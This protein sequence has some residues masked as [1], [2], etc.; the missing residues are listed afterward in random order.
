MKS[1][2]KTIGSLTV[3]KIIA[4][5]TGLAY[6]VLQ[7]RYF[8][9]NAAMDA[10]FVALTAVY[11][12]TSIL[13]SGQLAEVFL[14][15]YLKLKSEHSADQAHQ[16]FSAL[17]NRG[18][19]VMA[20]FS[21]V[22]SFLAPVIIQMLGV[23]LQQEY[24]ILAIDFFRVA[25]LI[26]LLTLF[27]AFVNS[28]LNAEHVYGRTELTG[29]INSLLSLILIVLFHQAVGLWILVYALLAGKVVEL[30]TGIF[31]LNRAGVRYYPIL[32]VAGY[33][34]N[35][36]LKV[37]FVTSG[38]VGATQL[39]TTVL[40]AV[41][42][43][44]PEG[45]LSIFNYVKQLSTKGSG[46]VLTPISTIFF[47][48]FATLVSQ[49]KANL[50]SYL[51]K[52]LMAILVIAGTM[53]ALIV[54]VGNEMLS[55][56]WSEKSLTPSNFKL[57][58]LMLVLNFTGIFFSAV[59]GIFRKSAISMGA[60]KQLYARWIGV[61]LFCAASSYGIIT[62]SGI[63]GLVFILPLNMILMAA[64]SIYSAYLEGIDVSALLK[65]LLFH[66]SGI[67]LLFVLAIST[68][69]I[70]Y[71]TLPLENNVIMSFAVKLLAIG[72]LYVFGAIVFREKI[73]GVLKVNK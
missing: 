31:F 36:F 38:Y 39:Y 26:I 16:L 44:L 20:V 58:Y 45:V 5:V 49:H 43:M 57:A 48:K 27:S 60:A 54:L 51:T 15:E 19:V 64:V 34:L 61:Q 23:G 53:L 32:R 42:S 1:T 73:L 9:A 67:L 14:P 28:A 29:L 41:T 21:L 71:L 55:L 56:L 37:L 33:D 68:C 3:L 35:R 25:L 65:K 46:I 69:S 11:V 50:T 52:P 17:L 63:F 22:V 4:A 6:S 10:Y 59:G 66:N 47:S 24:Q 7:V 30:L 62:A 40:T 2:L 70:F 72:A 8:G 13:Q 18:L 12:I